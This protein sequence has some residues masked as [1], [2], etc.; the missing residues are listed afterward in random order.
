MIHYQLVINQSDVFAE[1]S[2]L[3]EYTGSKLVD[4]QGDHRDEVWGTPLDFME[5]P[6]LWREAQVAFEHAVRDFADGDG[7]L[8]G[9]GRYSISLSVSSR[10]RLFGL[11]DMAQMYFVRSVLG[12]W[13][14]ISCK[15]VAD[16]SLMAAQ[17]AL[18]EVVR[19]LYG[20]HEPELGGGV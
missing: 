1:V 10:T 18:E 6:N 5:L 17:G 14:T 12:R 20:V 2:K 11:R 13:F 4:E 16:V 8:D 15:P 3:S 9:R 19:M 7:V